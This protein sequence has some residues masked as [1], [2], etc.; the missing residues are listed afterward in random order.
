MLVLPSHLEG[1]GMPVVEAM[2]TGVPAIVSDRGALP[3]VGGDAVQV[4]KAEDV[5]GFAAAM[6]LY[7]TTPGAAEQAI[8][9]GIVQARRYSWDSSAAALLQRYRDIA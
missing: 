2:A 6:R 1:F 8:A 3:E 7:L 5:D 9:R 4:V